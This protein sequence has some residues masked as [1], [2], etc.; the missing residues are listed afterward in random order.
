MARKRRMRSRRAKAAP[1]R[2]NPIARVVKAK[3]VQVRP[4]RRRP[5][6]E[7][8]EWDGDGGS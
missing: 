8:S 6:P 3:T 2:R 5:P 1:K 4:G 7:R